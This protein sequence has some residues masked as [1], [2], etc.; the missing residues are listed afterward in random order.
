VRMLS[1]PGMSVSAQ[2]VSNAVLHACRMAF[3][4]RDATDRM[5][6]ENSRA[7]VY[8]LHPR[9]VAWL[10]DARVYIDTRLDPATMERLDKSRPVR[11]SRHCGAPG[12]PVDRP[13]VRDKYAAALAAAGQVTCAGNG[14]I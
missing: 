1:G 4:W 6:A 13:A 3:G 9:D 11:H 14:L 12:G 5:K 7:A 10:N 2:Q 8:H